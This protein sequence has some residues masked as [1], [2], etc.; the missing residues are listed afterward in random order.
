MDPES[1]LFVDNDHAQVLECDCSLKQRMGPDDDPTAVLDHRFRVRG[2]EGLRVVDASAMP[3][4]ICGNI[5]ASVIMM[6]E[7]AA[8]MILNKPLL[9][10]FDPGAAAEPK[11]TTT[12]EAQ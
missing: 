3:D 5:H 10:P 8:D 9:P 12:L 7:R 1:V 2:V 6:A 4:M 11:T